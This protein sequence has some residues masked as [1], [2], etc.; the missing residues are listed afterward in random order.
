MDCKDHSLIVHVAVLHHSSA[1]LLKYRDPSLRDN[2]TGWF[3]PNDSLKHAEHPEVG[4]QR[5]VKEQT[6]IDKASFKLAQIESF[7]GDNGSWHLIFDYI[8]IPNSKHLMKG[9]EISS[10]EW[11]RL[12]QLPESKEF[13]HDGWSRSILV[14][15]T[16]DIPIPK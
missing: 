2:Q 5:V 14:K 1:L 15:L 13:A 3:M 16:S 12:D 11:F 10:A 8:A 4:A 9:K 7:V 6:G